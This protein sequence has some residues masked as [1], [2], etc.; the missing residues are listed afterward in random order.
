PAPAPAPVPQ[1]SLLQTRRAS[2][3]RYSITSN[4]TARV[5]GAGTPAALR[6]MPGTHRM[7]SPLLTTGYRGRTLRGTRASIK[8]R[9]TGRCPTPPS[10]TKESPRAG[11]R[12]SHV[13]LSTQVVHVVRSICVGAAAGDQVISNSPNRAEPRSPVGHTCSRAQTTPKIGRAHV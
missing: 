2:A 11:A 1:W 7:V 5:P 10:G 4:L 3:Q 6:Q 9:R 8:R 13:V 12:T